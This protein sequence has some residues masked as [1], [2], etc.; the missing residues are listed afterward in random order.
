MKLHAAFGF[1]E[2]GG[3]YVLSGADPQENRACL[4]LMTIS[5]IADITDSRPTRKVLVFLRKTDLQEWGMKLLSYTSDVPMRKIRKG[6]FV[7]D[8]WRNFA[9]ATEDLAR[10][11]VHLYESV[12]VLNDCVSYCRSQHKTGNCFDA[13][14][15]DGLTAQEESDLG[16]GGEVRSALSA[17]AKDL[18]VSI[19]TS[20]PTYKG[21]QKPMLERVF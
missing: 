16:D 2:K 7:A 15:I 18:Q 1:F 13:V 8:D 4:T 19:V 11:G 9:T 14:V 10:V 6:D 5:N 20:S 17:L 3:I 21:K 12:D